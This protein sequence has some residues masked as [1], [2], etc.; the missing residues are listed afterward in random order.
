MCRLIHCFRFVEA[1]Q[2]SCIFIELV[3]PI[4]HLID[5]MMNYNLEPAEPVFEAGESI[6]DT[7][8][9]IRHITKTSLDEI[10]LFGESLIQATFQ[11][12]FCDVVVLLWHIHSHTVS[13]PPSHTAKL[14]CQPPLPLARRGFLL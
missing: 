14:V 6:I 3:E 13:R 10:R 5:K 9:P 7:G 11:I 12:F 1:L 2:T 4:F 8:K